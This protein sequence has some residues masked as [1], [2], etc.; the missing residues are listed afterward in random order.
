MS[1]KPR[2]SGARAALEYF[3]IPDDDDDSRLAEYAHRKQATVIRL[4]E[5]GD[6]HAYPDSLRFIIA[7][8]DA[9]IRVAA[10]SSSKNAKLFLR[11][12][13]LDS[14]AQE[15][16]IVSPSLR[17]GLTLL[18]YFDADVSGRDFAHGKPHP[19][20]FLTAAHEL[21]AA[22]KDTIVMED[23]T[24]GVEAAKAGGMGAIGI[25]RANDADLLAAAHADIVVTTLD[26][27]DFGALTDGRLATKKG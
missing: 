4:I 22:P 20:M 21:G 8:K 7:V 13:R 3:R 1:G 14:F 25:A 10:A 2:M 27:V 9:G 23:A 6:F 24:A 11:K 16:G 17:P 5:A 18:D 12:I 19:E 15:Q 26:D